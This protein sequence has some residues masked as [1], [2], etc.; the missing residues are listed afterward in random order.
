[1][2]LRV[3]GGG[4][5]SWQQR[6][7]DPQCAPHPLGCAQ[8]RC[9][10]APL[11]PLGLWVRRPA[12]PFS[13]SRSPCPAWP[14]WVSW[15]RASR[16]RAGGGHCTLL[17]WAWFPAAAV[18]PETQISETHWSRALA[19]WEHLCPEPLRR[20]RSVW[21]SEAG[22][23]GQGPGPRLLRPGGPALAVKSLGM[24]LAA[25]QPRQ[26]LRWVNPGPGS[27]EQ[28]RG[29]TPLRSNAGPRPRSVSP[30]HWGHPQ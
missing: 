27:T 3:Y 17:G 21:D 19:Q 5:Y 30:Q 26:S 6:S 4:S 20:G 9:L 18:V 16:R 15:A 10:S 7:R 12:A 1:M 25:G 22:V 8:A 2:G 29:P 23:H 14:G 28:G 24:G 13:A 11:E